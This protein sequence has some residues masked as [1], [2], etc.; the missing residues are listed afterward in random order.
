MRNPDLFVRVSTPRG[1]FSVP[2]AVAARSSWRVLKR[3]AT[4]ASG[5]PLPPKLREPRLAATPIPTDPEIASGETS[6]ESE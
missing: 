6:E 4:D 1:H 2:A 3:P 5:R